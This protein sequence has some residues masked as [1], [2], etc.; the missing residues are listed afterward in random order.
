MCCSCF[1][2]QPRQVVCF[3]FQEARTSLHVKARADQPGVK[4]SPKKWHLNAIWGTYNR[5]GLRCNGGPTLGKEEQRVQYPGRSGDFSPYHLH[6]YFHSARKTA[7]S[8]FNFADVSSKLTP[9]VRAWRWKIVNK[10]ALKARG[11]LS[12]KWMGSQRR[13]S[14][15]L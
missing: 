9:P 15:S 11:F 5:D 14:M 12:S 1:K 10:R 2:Q 6:D 7:T 8:R 3:S 4:C 13:Q